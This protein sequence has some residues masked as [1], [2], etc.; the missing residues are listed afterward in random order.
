[1]KSIVQKISA[2]HFAFLLSVFL[3]LCCLPTR[4]QQIADEISRMNR[5]MENL[6]GK[7]NLSELAEIYL[8][9]AVL[10]SP[11]GNLVKGR[12][13]IDN[14]WTRIE[15]P[16][17]WTLEVIF[18]TEDEQEI[19]SHEFW[20]RLETKPPDWNTAVPDSLKKN[21]VFQLGHSTLKTVWQGSERTSEVDF[22][23]VW[24]KTPA[25]YRILADSYTW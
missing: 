18:V 4:S 1:M 7:G 22:L 9:E 14:Y 11:G 23:L 12:S 10:L 8:D 25:G 5:Q 3:F 13:E 19:Y 2:N 16:V 15:S 17:S 24:K 21:L 6:F 20:S